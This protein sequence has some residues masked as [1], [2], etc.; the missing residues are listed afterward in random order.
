M[1]KG[2]YCYNCSVWHTLIIVWMVDGREAGVVMT[3]PL[4][5]Q[6]SLPR[7][8]RLESTVKNASEIYRPAVGLLIIGGETWMVPSGRGPSLRLCSEITEEHNSGTMQW[9][10]RL[11][12]LFPSVS[13]DTHLTSIGFTNYQVPD[14]YLQPN[15]A[16][17]RAPQRMSTDP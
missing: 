11:C 17:R 10:R 8:K 1:N 7:W 13:A 3:A 9:Q 4:S 12:F 2:A 6:L 5:Q 16:G 14:C 15:P